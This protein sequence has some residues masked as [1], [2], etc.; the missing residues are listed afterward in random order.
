MPHF[1]NRIL[2]AL[3]PT[4]LEDI[5][6]H[7]RVV[8]LNH[9]QI[10]ADSHQRIR[11]VYFPHGGILSCVVETETGWGIET[12]MIGVD[13]VFGAAQAMDHGV[14]LNKVLV[15]LPTQAT[16][17]DASVVRDLAS[18]S[19]EFRELIARYEHFTFAQAQQ[20]CVCNALHNVEQR[21]C[22][23]LVRMHDLV[24]TELPITQEFLAQMMGVRRTSVTTVASQMQSKGM[25]SYRRGKMSILDID[26]VRKNGCECADAI[27]EHHH[28]MFGTIAAV[29]G[30]SRSDT[31]PRVEY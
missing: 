25:I 30:R 18:S 29:G 6:P 5:R 3:N 1:K 23:W 16:V 15:Q 20:S 2:A 9:G 8:G 22:K 10:L 24:G 4:D 19:P 7:L 28:Q 31:E 21:M 26:L 13:G 17:V 11:T 27:R 14:S 12:A